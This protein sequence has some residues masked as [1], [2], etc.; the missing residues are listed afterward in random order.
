MDKISNVSSFSSIRKRRT[1]TNYNPGFSTSSKAS[2]KQRKKVKKDNVLRKSY[3]SSVAS[4][5]S[6]HSSEAGLWKKRPNWEE[7]DNLD[8]NLFDEDVASASTMNS[9]RA[10]KKSKANKST[11]KGRSSKKHIAKARMTQNFNFVTSSQKKAGKK[12]KVYN[13]QVNGAPEEED[14]VDVSIVFQEVD[15]NF[16]VNKIPHT[17]EIK[18]SPE[19]KSLKKQQSLRKSRVKPYGD[20]RKKKSKAQAKK[21]LEIKMEGDSFNKD[22][23]RQANPPLRGSNPPKPKYAQNDENDETLSLSP[24]QKSKSKMEDEE[25][26]SFD[27]SENREQSFHMQY[28]DT[29]IRPLYRPPIRRERIKTE[30]EEKISET[31]ARSMSVRNTPKTQSEHSMVTESAAR[32]RRST[33]YLPDEGYKDLQQYENFKDDLEPLYEEG[34]EDFESERDSFTSTQKI[35]NNNEMEYIAP[36]TSGYG[37]VKSSSSHMRRKSKSE[38]SILSHT[39]SHSS[40]VKSRI[41]RYGK[42]KHERETAL[43]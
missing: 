25:G 18:S 8:K 3:N 9:V 22:I 14:N 17:K 2:F 41:R 30:V 27:Q 26:N 37:S 39:M 24:I 23:L 21:A 28:R 35:T 10:N 5:M 32:S 13:Y 6:K 11:K 16:M 1:N 40:H 33:T 31:P 43:R 38:K 19:S 7:F 29:A 36:E 34:T 20:Q 12:S 42:N 4:T 15:S